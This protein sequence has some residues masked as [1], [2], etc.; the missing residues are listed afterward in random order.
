MT[1]C[2]KFTNYVYQNNVTCTENGTELAT[3]DNGCGETDSRE[4]A[5]TA[6]GHTYGDPTWLWSKSYHSATATFPARRRTT[7][8]P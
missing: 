2:V 4:V 5:G 3:C 6:T 1:F 7:R 8:R